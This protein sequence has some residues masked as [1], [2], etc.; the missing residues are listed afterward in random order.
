M[1]KILAYLLIVI[2][3]LI[4]SYLYYDNRNLKQGLAESIDH[5][6]SLEAWQRADSLFFSGEEQA[7]RSAWQE[8]AGQT[9]FMKAARARFTFLEQ[10]E[11]NEQ[12]RSAAL[13]SLKR[14][15][16][17]S[18]QLNRADKAT[19][20]NLEQR[21]RRT[22]TQLGNLSDS[23]DSLSSHYAQEINSREE[24]AA[25]Q[26]VRLQTQESKIADLEQE[27]Q[28]KHILKFKS[29]AGVDIAYIGEVKDGKAHGYGIGIWANGTSYRG[30]WQ[31]GKK[32]GQGVYEYPEGEKFEGDF[33]KDKRQGFGTYV[34]KN[35]DRYEGQWLQDLRHGEGFITNNKGE[36]VRGGIWEKDVLEQKQKTN[37]ANRK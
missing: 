1:K 15:L 26:A 37:G 29:P 14:T 10:L 5:Q 3:V 35:G 23:I 24:L 31:E 22:G 25:L 33:V 21:L 28:S 18:T 6:L 17:Y 2:A 12:L 36:I 7:A 16:A 8:Q 4:A 19:I 27:A 34:W 9:A 32:H 11:I 30:Q 13:D 20:N